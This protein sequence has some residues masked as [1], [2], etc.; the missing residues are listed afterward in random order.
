MNPSR[1]IFIFSLLIALVFN[2]CQQGYQPGKGIKI[3]PEGKI[4]IPEIEALLSFVDNS[5]DYI[6]TSSMPNLVSADDVYENLNRYFIIDIRD[7]ELYK[8]GHING[9][10]NVDMSLLLDYLDKKV[11]ASVYDK[12]VIV[13]TNGQSSA[14]VTGVLRLIGYSNAFSLSYGMST[15][16]PKL[17]KWSSKIS[18]KYTHLLEKTNNDL[19]KTYDFPPIKTGGTCGAEILNARGVTLLNTPFKRLKISADRLF[20]ELDE[21][22]IMAYMPK[23]EY[24]KGHIPGA[25]LYEPRVS[26][27]KDA[28]LNTLPSNN[29]KILV[30]DYTGQK[31]AFVMAYLRLLGY[32]AFFMPMGAN[33]FMYQK[34]KANKKPIFVAK[35]RVFDFPM[36][37]GNAPTDKAFE[38][39]IKTN[40]PAPVKKKKVVRRKK[41]EVEG[42]CS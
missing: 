23:E 31:A 10:V 9:A 33:S 32:N 11:A 8:A 3:V 24:D 14:Y 2:S 38:K 37:K 27:T 34:L 30:Y 21:F 4:D 5:G 42:G 16:N 6:N 28:L 13:C 26:L 18:N 15:W 36:V 17:D 22:H 25:F 7:R 19:L 40:G 29:K 12:L 41:K 20:K 1:Y 35:D 39:E